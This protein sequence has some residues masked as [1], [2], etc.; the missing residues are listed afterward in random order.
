MDEDERLIIASSI[1]ID[2]ALLSID[3]DKPKCHF[4]EFI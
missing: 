4:G 1:D 2:K 3:K